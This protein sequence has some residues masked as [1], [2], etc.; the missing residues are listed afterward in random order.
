LTTRNWTNPAGGA[1]NTPGNWFG[2]VVPGPNDVATF[3][4]ADS[5]TVDLPGDASV[6]DLAVN[7]PTFKFV[8]TSLFDMHDANFTA[9]NTTKVGVNGSG[10]LTLERHS[11]PTS[12]PVTFSTGALT[13]GQ[14]GNG[15]LY[16]NPVLP[17]PALPPTGPINL[18]VGGLVQVGQASSGSGGTFFLAGGMTSGATTIDDGFVTD[19]GSW[20]NPGAFSVQNASELHIDAGGLT[21]GNFQLGR[22]N[23]GST[24][25]MTIGSTDPQGNPI[26]GSL[27]TAAMTLAP[28]GSTDGTD[29]Q[30]K[31]SPITTSGPAV[32]AA[33]RT[34]ANSN[35]SMYGTALPGGGFLYAT[36]DISGALTVGQ[37]GGQATL[38]VG[39]IATLTSGDGNIGL[40]ADL[41]TGTPANGTVSLLGDKSSWAVNGTLSIGSG[42]VG[43]LNLGDHSG[44][45]IQKILSLGSRGTVNLGNS[46]ITADQLSNSGG[47]FSGYGILVFNRALPNNYVAI[48]NPG[49]T[50]TGYDPDIEAANG[51]VYSSGPAQIGAKLVGGSITSASGYLSKN[52]FIGHGSIFGDLTFQEP[53]DPKLTSGLVLDGVMQADSVTFGGHRTV[54]SDAI[55]GDAPGTIPNGYGQ[56][57]L[58]DGA[59]DLGSATLDLNVA[60]G[61]QPTPGE[62][63]TIVDNRG[64]QPVKGMLSLL[65]DPTTNPPTYTPLPEGAFFKAGG[66]YFTI[67]Y[68]GGDGNDV[69]LIANRP[70]VA[71]AGGP[72]TVAEGGSVTLT[73]ANSTDPEQAA[74]A[75]SYAWDLNG[76]GIFGEVGP[77]ATHGDELG[78][79][80]TFNA[81]DLD[82]PG[83]YTVSVLVTDVGGLTSVATATINVVNTPPTAVFTADTNV[84]EGSDATV[85]FLSPFDPSAADTNAGFTY[86]FD[87]NNDG[88]FEVS[89]PVS[90]AT[91][92]GA[93]LPDGPADHVVHGRI[94]DRDGDFTDYTT[95]IHVVNVPPQATFNAPT[96]A[97]E[98]DPITLSLT[99][100]TDASAVD[101][102]FG[103]AY[104]FDFGNG[105][106]PWTNTPTAI[107]PALK[108]GDVTVRA[109]IRDKDF[110]VTEY[111]QTMAVANVAPVVSAGPD[112]TIARGATFIRSGSFAD[113]GAEFWQG[114]VS[115]GDGTNPQGLALLPNKTFSLRHA[116]AIP[117]TYT[118][119]V[120]VNDSSGAGGVGTFH[121]TVPVPR[122]HPG[123]YD[124]DG[125]ADLTVYRPST[126]QWIIQ[127]S[128]KGLRSM[129]FGAPG[130]TIPVPGDY[131]GD[132]KTDLA[133]YTPATAQW[134]IFQ[135]S[136]GLRVVTFGAPNTDIPVPADYDGDGKT[137]LAVYRPTT[138]Q[139][140]ILRS[141]LGPEVVSL[142]G[143][144]DKPVPADYDGDGKADIAVYRA[145]T[146]Q[147]LILQSSAGPRV[148]T[149]GAR[150]L[151]KPIPADYDGD[152]KA[153]IAVY[154]PSTSQFFI[155]QSSGGSRAVTFGAKNL[156]IP[157]TGD[158]D[159][160]G[161]ADI[162]VYRPTTG[163]WLILQ[164]SGGG[165]IQVVP[166][167]SRQDVPLAVPLSYRYT[168]G[169]TAFSVRAASFATSPAPAI[170]LPLAPPVDPAAGTDGTS[171]T[172]RRRRV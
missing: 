77:S 100:P 148:V 89:G 35:L 169:L 153:D 119:S 58:R 110:G 40:G 66:Q 2:G 140:I 32:L 85:R 71:N 113:P 60:N 146:A 103:F 21:A 18:N 29:L 59:L 137:D 53:D 94:T 108:A 112:V 141:T 129:V 168:G 50:V 25:R 91:I 63:F 131:D 80:V 57:V 27:A 156:D 65:T 99:D 17:A 98:G 41:A 33:S 128:T 149:F 23:N 42:G 51:Y 154:R 83:T 124:G 161:K 82:G 61:F 31:W 47:T 111:T 142:G 145:S 157:L 130:R 13:I 78:M 164:S 109:K 143:P 159:G 106:G 26:Q 69:Q 151:D 117:G 73:A 6:G 4:L 36:W 127:Q 163:Q 171:A 19:D 118:L 79:N 20:T 90:V 138:G 16:V 28:G 39:N 52:Q 133:V 9:Q 139:W 70:P 87:F 46:L 125:K 49:G 45:A 14:V 155:L 8:A 68:K 165:R 38:N 152:G 147:W 114:F 67:T 95:T 84:P 1:F 3:N 24:A 134:Q 12:V 92:P 76:N 86:S 115:Y 55:Q 105:Y 167:T 10:S 122:T 123:D 74:S 144:I 126:A 101:T 96:S 44:V 104:D 34:T 5:G 107:A 93:D 72:Y 160:D 43:T 97:T 15:F 166:G 11:Q 81:G 7:D 116:Y 75:L 172:G 102:S 136:G 88:H 37:L 158:F 150:N 48:P 135:S 22:S 132:G 56:L 162:A 62:R 30:D 64:T 170:A 120:T 54:F 121:V